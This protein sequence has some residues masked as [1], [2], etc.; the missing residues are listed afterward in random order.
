VNILLVGIFTAF[1]NLHENLHGAVK[2]PLE[3]ARIEFTRPLHCA[4][5]LAGDYDQ[6]GLLNRDAVVR[7]AQDF[8]LAVRSLR[9]TGTN[10]SGA[11]KIGSGAYE[12]NQ[13]RQESEG[14]RKR[15]L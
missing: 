7:V 3:P 14:Q 8:A 13:F 2:I 5:L 10:L 6:I 11:Y 1:G 15:S 9:W 12:R 4:S